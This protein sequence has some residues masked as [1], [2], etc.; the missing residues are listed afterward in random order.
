MTTQGSFKRDYEVAKLKAKCKALEYE[1]DMLKSLFQSLYLNQTPTSDTRVGVTSKPPKQP[2]QKPV[3]QG[4]V[5][6][7]ADF[8]DYDEEGLEEF[9]EED[10]NDYAFDEEEEYYDE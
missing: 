4:L 2:T 3:P 8:E 1:N 10:E 9:E 6:T 7:K 5:F